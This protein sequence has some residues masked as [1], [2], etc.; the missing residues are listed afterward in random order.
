MTKLY[1]Q[2]S[3]K[4]KRQTLRNNMPL[5]EK[6]VWAKLRNQQVE[7]C[8]FRRQYSIDKFVVDFYS[9]ELR[10]AIEID[11]DS[12]YEDGVPEYDRE[13]QAFL[14][15]KGTRFLRFTNQEV[16][17]D[18][19]GVVEKIREVISRLREV[20]SPEPSSDKGYRV[21]PSWIT[22]LNPPL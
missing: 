20:T 21:H 11:G 6:I 22:P 14:E 7:S 12:H 8:K 18:I 3:E 1:N 9:S 16:Y 10:L 2:T 17:Q 13:R 5:C 15:S 4:Q 19:D